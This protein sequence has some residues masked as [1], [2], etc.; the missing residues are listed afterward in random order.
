MCFS[1]T[2]SFTAGI[3]LTAAGGAAVTYAGK[4]PERLF[5]ATPL[6]FGVQQL[7]EGVV[8]LSFA[9]P[10]LQSVATFVYVLFSHI[11]WPTFIPLA[12]LL[13]EP[14]PW[15]RKLLSLCTAVGV[16]V[17]AYFL[18][19]FVSHLAFKVIGFHFQ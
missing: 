9:H 19:N 17:S 11:V 6:L 10:A 8:W 3:A 12:I 15:R 13:M 18:Y 4:K 7:T 16:V 5:A 1:A 14:S 2:A